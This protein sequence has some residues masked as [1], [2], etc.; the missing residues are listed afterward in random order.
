MGSIIKILILYKTPFWR[1]KN[2]SGEVV[3]DCVDG[4]TFNVYY[5]IILYFILN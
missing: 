4:P 2:Y 3:S 1:N 5:L